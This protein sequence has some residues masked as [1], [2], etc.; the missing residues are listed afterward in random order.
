MPE[1]APEEEEDSPL[2]DAPDSVELEGSAES[3]QEEQQMKA[4]PDL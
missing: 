3:D 1:L 2:E 4:E